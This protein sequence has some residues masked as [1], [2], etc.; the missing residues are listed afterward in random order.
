M[1]ARVRVRLIVAAAA[2][3]AGAAAGT[4]AL[5]SGRDGEGESTRPPL[6]LGVVLA[7]GP[8]ARALLAAEQAYERG[9]PEEARQG[10]TAVLGRDPSS[11]PAAVGAAI[12]GWPSGTLERLTDLAREHP[13]SGV[14]L[15]HLGLALYTD[16]EQGA[17]V[18]RWREAEV[19]DPDSPAAVRAEDLL[20]PEM[21]PGRPFFIP[22]AGNPSGLAGLGPKAQL[23]E[24]ERRAEKGGVLDRLLYGSVLQRLGRPVSARGAFDAAVAIAPKNLQA[25]TAA[26]VARFDK[27]D[28]SRAFSRLGPL[29]AA[30]PT[31]AVVRFHLG[32]MLVWVGQVKASRRQ[33]ELARKA[34]PTSV[35]GRE[36]GRLLSRLEDVRTS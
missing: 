9:H 27:D 5:L 2:L 35:Y 21:P 23:D 1:S 29:A 16:G 12:A 31:S 20:H 3:A 4:I 26:A 32:L 8:E 24:L 28:P 33:L 36:A 10:F 6:E 22:S 19:R 34:A 14:V 30:H 25:L 11:V 18:E 7:D 13:K 15:L 17:A